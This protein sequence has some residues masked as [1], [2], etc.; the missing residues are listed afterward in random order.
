MRVKTENHERGT[1]L[2]ILDGYRT[3]ELVVMGTT[4][5]PQVFPSIESA[6]QFC[7]DVG[8]QLVTEGAR[9]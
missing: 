8:Y 7:T 6:I 2:R 9:A 3:G 4:D 1:V 5:F